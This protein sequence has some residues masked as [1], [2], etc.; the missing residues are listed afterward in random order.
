M[1]KR[2]RF[3]AGV[4]AGLGIGG[5]VT[6]RSATQQMPRDRTP[7]EQHASERAAFDRKAGEM[8]R[9]AAQKP[10]DA[11]AQ[12]LLGTLYY[13]RSRDP[14]LGADERRGYL[15]RGVAAEDRAL[16]ANPDYVEALVYKNILL[17][18]Q[19]A[20]ESDP[21]T[22]DDLIRQ[23]DALRNRALDRRQSQATQAIPAGTVVTTNVPPPPPPGG[24]SEPIKWVYAETEIAA[25]GKAPVQTR[26][27]RPIYAPMVIASGI[28]GQVVLEAGIDARGKVG[29]VRV[30]QS[31]AMLT[32]ATID[33]VRQWEFDPASVAEHAS[34]TVTATFTPPVR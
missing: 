32:Q 15:A 6:A 21:A 19:A 12:H 2:I 16:A 33:A 18:T 28:Q 1:S 13:E 3:A 20:M 4:F 22:R 27:V 17:R 5:I 8:E 7:T 31:V 29:Q 14:S 9:I 25:A 23:A 26:H 30:V 11:Q 34:I 24:V 10:R